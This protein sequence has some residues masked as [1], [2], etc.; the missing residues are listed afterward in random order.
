M[1]LTKI[2]QLIAHVLLFVMLLGLIHAEEM[3][4]ILSADI[5]DQKALEDYIFVPTLSTGETLNS[6]RFKAASHLAFGESCRYNFTLYLMLF[7]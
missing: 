7:S 1:R 2:L 6:V 3:T 4:K 5:E